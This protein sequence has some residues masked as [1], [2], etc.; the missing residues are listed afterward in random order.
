VARELGVEYLLEGS[1]RRAGNR[2]RVTA[3]LVSAERGTHMWAERYDRELADIFNVQ[4]EVTASIVGM[5]TIGLEDEVLER[6]KRKRPENMF[7]YEHWLRGKRLLWTHG[8]KNLQ[9]R[10]HFEGALAV[11]PNFSRAY[12]GLAV[13]YM[14]VALDF[15]SAEDFRSANANAR[16][17]AEN[18]LALDEADYQAHMALAWPCLYQGDYARMKKH[19]ERSLM[20]NSN[21]ADTLANAAYLLMMY[22]EA[23]EAVR[24]GEKAMLLNPRHPDW[25]SAFL[26]GA[27][28]TARRYPE[29]LAYRMQAADVWVDSPF[30]GAAVLAHMGRLDEARRWADRGVKRLRS[31]PG[32]SAPAS[33][34]YIQMM[35]DN[36]PYR[37]AD[38]RDH[39]ANGMRLAGVP[40]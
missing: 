10:K 37:L 27:L 24:C 29:A 39:F 26:S 13:T 22:G 33:R 23:D 38:D 19:V 21:D 14:L 20:L 35:L 2:I 32:G 11:D 5:L 40:E 4:D 1:V 8:Q 9:A 16:K 36:N 6:A 25:Y 3:Q 28:F 15:P 7:A 30:W 17:F 12:S 31:L 34:G 18:A